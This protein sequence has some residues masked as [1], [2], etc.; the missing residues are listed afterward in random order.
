MYARLPANPLHLSF[1]HPDLL[2]Q[3]E[4]LGFQRLGV[5]GLELDQLGYQA[6]GGVQGGEEHDQRPRLAR[7]EPWRRLAT[8]APRTRRHICTP[9]LVSHDNSALVIGFAGHRS[10]PHRACQ[11]IT[12]SG[13]AGVSA[14]SLENQ[15]ELSSIGVV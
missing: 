8:A 14:D 2:A 7:S 3:G 1:Q 4:H 6:E 11:S 5:S 10:T 9:H 15:Q 12:K 13:R